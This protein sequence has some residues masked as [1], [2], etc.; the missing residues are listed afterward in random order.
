M[1][2]APRPTSNPL[3]LQSPCPAPRRSCFRRIAGVRALVLAALA[4]AACATPGPDALEEGERIRLG[5]RFALGQID[6]RA[7]AVG[8]IDAERLL[9][10]ALERAL[11]ERK[12]RWS[13]DAAEDHYL[14]NMEIAAYEPGN[15]FKRWLLPG[16]GATILHV[17]GA[18][19][20]PRDASVAAAIDHQRSVYFGGAYTIGAWSRIFDSVARDI[21]RD[22]E[23][24]ARGT[25]FFVRLAPW[26]HH[27]IDIPA[28]EQPRTLA[29]GPFA[30]ARSERGRIGERH[31]T[32]GV[33]MG[34]I[35][36]ARDVVE[37]LREA[38]SDDLRAAGHTLLEAGAPAIRPTSLKCC[39]PRSRSPHAGGP[40]DIRS[41]ERPR[42]CAEQHLRRLRGDPGLQD[43][44]AIL[45]SRAAH[46]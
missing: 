42:G 6:G 13:G 1:H 8:E 9:R 7:P 28:A 22:L 41:A 10:E 24:H 30:D 16:H 31:A 39:L 3:R 35:H 23:H 44:A 2:C 21:A 4:S 19:V 33:S 26:S 15:A 5:A 11:A 38:V 37:Y 18:L 45:Q 29:V 36:F 20:D 34:D 14:L 43:C 27:D 12:L 17:Q 32:Y 25:G 46:R 40:A